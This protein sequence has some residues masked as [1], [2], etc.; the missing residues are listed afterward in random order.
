LH[1]SEPVGP[2]IRVDSGV[3]QGMTI[4]IDYDPIMA[5][6]IVHAPDRTTAITKMIDA[7]NNYKFL[8]VKTSKKFMI[9][10]LRHEEFAAG[11]TF[12]SFI[13]KNMGDRDNGVSDSRELAAAIAAVAEATSVRAVSGGGDGDHEPPTPWQ[14]VGNWQIGDAIHVER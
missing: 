3:W 1:Y 9:D 6:L 14:T 4:T 2:G 5:K 7:L 8:G 13:E 10:V 11:N 12:T